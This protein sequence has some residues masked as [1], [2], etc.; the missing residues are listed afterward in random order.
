MS[1]GLGEQR[2]DGDGDANTDAWWDRL[3]GDMTALILSKLPLRSML[4]ASAVCKAWRAAAIRASTLPRHGRRRTHPW[5]F[6]HGRSNGVLPHAGRRNAFAFDPDEPSSWVSFTLPPDFVAGAGGFAFA[7]P[8]P[9]RLAFAPL[10]REL[11]GG[12]TAM[13]HAPPLASPRYNNPVV[14]AVAAP[15]S[16]DGERLLLLVAGGGGFPGGLVDIDDHLPTELYECDHHGDAAAG[17]WVQC[18]PLPE[19][20]GSA[21]SS[22]SS[23]SLSISPALVGGRFLFACGIHSCAV[24][25]FDLS[26][27]A[28]A[29]PPRE[30]CSPPVVPRLAAAFVATARR[31]RRLLLA[32]VVEEEGQRRALGVWEVEPDTL[33]A[34]RVGEMPAEMAAA[35]LGSGGVRCVGQ[36]GVIYV[37]GEEEHGGYRACACV[38][39]GGNDGRGGEEELA[40]RW[41]WLPPLP[42]AAGRSGIRRMAA[43]CSPV[44]LRNYFHAD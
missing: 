30:V 39:I 24:S 12:I 37:V 9:S 11:C 23:S 40:C 43:F 18:A 42:A 28:W 7:A 33:A 22:S 29:A 26:R 20:L 17:V 16:R 1:D 27:R 15:G 31:G 21:A 32:G 13:R 34:S 4:R 38:V 14:A 35:V 25:A 8:S 10:L 36:D 5:L 2:E 19:E 44:L 3:G 6:L 41:S